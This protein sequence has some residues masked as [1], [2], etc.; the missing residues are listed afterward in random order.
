[1]ENFQRILQEGWSEQ[2]LSDICAVDWGNT[3]LTKSSY[4]P[5]GKYLAVSATGPDG[6]IDQ[7]EYKK[8][9]P[10]LSAI[11]ANCG[12]M[13]SP[14][15]DFT[16]IKNTIVFDSLDGKSDPGFLF[17]LLSSI[18]IPKRGGA[19]PFISKGD[20]QNL[21]VII[22]EKVS[23]QKKIAEILSTVD[24][25]IQ[26]T[27]E[28]I[29]STERLKNGLM[30]ELF[31]KGIGHEEFKKTKIG[32]V[33]SNWELAELGELCDVRDGTHD[34]PKYKT[35][36]VPLVTSKNLI[37]GSLDFSTAQLISFDD[38]TNISRR[39]IVDDGDILFGMIGTIG[40]PVLVKKD[41]EFS[42][43]NVALIKFF[44]REKS[45]INNQYLIQ[46]LRSSLTKDQFA[47]KLSGSTQKFISLGMI[48]KMTVV[49]PDKNEQENISAILSSVDKQ[50]SLNLAVKEKLEILK[51]GLM[52]DLLSGRVRI[53]FE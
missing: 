40:N 5:N 13:F 28:I 39:S 29:N 19:Q 17:Y 3:D 52:A 46:Y 34:S 25:E 32:D 15:E 42:I 18:D 9:T 7:S 43:K 12:R 23:E 38:H 16:A 44:E 51:K 11:G 27:D 6:R 22:P 31:T 41:R 10:V 49:L 35:E 36:G 20:L 24:D 21:K 53:K 14:D 45:K 47:Q 1:M 33:P 37:K 8:G 30:Q 50:I 4:I 48:R 2:K 26:K